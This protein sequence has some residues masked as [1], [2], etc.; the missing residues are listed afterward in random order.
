M[1]H[2][3]FEKKPPLRVKILTAKRLYEAEFH[4][5]RPCLVHS[6]P[7]FP[8][9]GNREFGKSENLSRNPLDGKVRIQKSIK[10]IAW[11]FLDLRQ[12]PRQDLEGVPLGG[13]ELQ[14]LILMRV[15]LE[16]FHINWSDYWSDYCCFL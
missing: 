6:I 15:A 1:W 3:L 16:S 11:K 7:L 2:R 5:L 14:S 10:K 12:K 8:F 4:K 13:L 9:P